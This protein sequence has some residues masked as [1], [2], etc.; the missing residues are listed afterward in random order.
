MPRFKV[1]M[2]K[3][4]EKQTQYDK[5]SKTDFKKNFFDPKQDKNNVRILP[6][7]SEEGIW[8]REV[9]YHYGVG[10]KSVVCPKRLLNKPCFVCDKVA[11]FRK[12]GDKELGLLADELRPKM[13]IYYNLVDLDD[14]GKGVQVY[15]S[16]VNVF[17][18]LLYYD[19]DEEWGNITDAD[20]GYDII[21]TREGKG[22]TSKYQVKLKK[23]PS[24][25]ASEE[26]L[27]TLNNLDNMVGKILSYEELKDLYES[28]PTSA[29]A[30]GKE[31]AA[32]V[33]KA[34]PRPVKEIEDIPEEIGKEVE[35]DDTITLTRAEVVKMSRKELKALVKDLG[36][37]ID[38]KDYDEDDEFR[39]AII[40]EC[41]LDSEEGDDAV[42]AKEKVENPGCF[43]YEYNESDSEC[44]VCKVSKDCK[45]AFKAKK[46]R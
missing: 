30:V 21:I 8:Y 4:K 45:V 23:N 9:P 11:E 19:L 20:K 24:P 5:T 39:D 12:S 22:K 25:I 13:R 28:E 44:V 1:D 7:W 33:A 29:P 2:S 40:K 3:I 15:G 41:G 17:K 14:T 27:N 35:S 43:G 6:P 36:L 37:D 32:P 38:Y 16:G 34:V 42:P 31:A 18:D 46:K 26:W 10:G